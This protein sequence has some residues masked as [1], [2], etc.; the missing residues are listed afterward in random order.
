MG[1]IFRDGCGEY[2]S[3]TIEMNEELG[4]GFKLETIEI[5]RKVN[6]RAIIRIPC[7]DAVVELKIH[8]RARWE[9]RPE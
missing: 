8:R 7:G 9:G 3:E 1:Q 6:D 5:I 4:R 2:V